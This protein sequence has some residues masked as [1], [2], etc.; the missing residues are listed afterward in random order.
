MDLEKEVSELIINL[1]LSLKRKTAAPQ[2][3]NLETLFK[4]S[5]Q[6]SFP[7]INETLIKGLSS[8]L[9]EI[10]DQGFNQ[11]RGDLEISQKRLEACQEILSIIDDTEGQTGESRG[12]IEIICVDQRPTNS[13]EAPNNVQ[14]L[15]G[16]N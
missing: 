12:Q 7:N 16:R 1:K 10:W 2:L 14:T 5:I 8:V 6:K 13:V 11:G 4:Y 3:Y 9:N 15:Q